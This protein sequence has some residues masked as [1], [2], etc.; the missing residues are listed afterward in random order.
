MEGVC[1]Y[2]V[3][4]DMRALEALDYL[5]DG[6]IDGLYSQEELYM[7]LGV[8]QKELKAL[9]IIR[10]KIIPQAAKHFYYILIQDLFMKGVL[11]QEEYDLLKEILWLNN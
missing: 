9:N 8:I 6:V 5:R 7:N 4:D 10:N 3:M 1:N 2:S 11:I